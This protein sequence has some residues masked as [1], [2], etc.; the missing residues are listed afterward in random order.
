MKALKQQREQ[1]PDSNGR[2]IGGRRR[3]DRRL[4]RASPCTSSPRLKEGAH[5]C[6]ALPARPVHARHPVVVDPVVRGELSGR[7]ADAEEGEEGER[8]WRER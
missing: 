7:A 4:S 2:D 8:G 3:A 5:A 6:G 1:A